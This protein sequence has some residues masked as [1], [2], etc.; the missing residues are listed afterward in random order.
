[1]IP[2]VERPFLQSALY[3]SDDQG[4][5]RDALMRGFNVVVI[6]DVEEARL[7]PACYPISSLLPPPA[8]VGIILNTDRTAPDYLQVEQYYL[9]SY[10]NYMASPNVED[11]IVNLIASMYKTNKPVLIYA[12]HEVEMQFKPLQVLCTFFATQFGINILAYECLFYQQQPPIFNPQPEYIYR[13]VDLLLAHN[14]VTKEEYSCIIPPGSVPSPRAISILLSDY[15]YI[16][17]TMEAA[18]T[19]AC[20]IIDTYRKQQE[21]GKVMPVVEMTKVLDDVRNQQVQ[22]LISNSNT[23]FG[24]VRQ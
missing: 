16:F 8:L 13:I 10:Y 20:N 6:V 23:H 5:I 3:C 24:P 14:F 17:P 12:E 4:A 18:L 22:Q 15:N 1:M 19:A 21:T 7:Y 11:H 2:H 9:S